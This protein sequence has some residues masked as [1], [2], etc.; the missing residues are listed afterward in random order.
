MAGT[1]NKFTSPLI[2]MESDVNTFSSAKWT[3]VSESNF[4]KMEE[5]VTAMFV[6]RQDANDLKKFEE[7]LLD[8]ST[9][10]SPNYGKWLKPEQIMEMISPEQADVQKVLD[11][12]ARFGVKD[13]KV[14]KFRDMVK[15]TMPVSTA[16]E[17]LSTE[18]SKFSSTVRPGVEVKRIT[19]PYF[20]PAEIADVIKYVDD[21]LRFPSMREPIIKLEGHSEGLKAGADPAFSSC[22]TKCSTFTTPAVLQEAYG[23]PTL[24]T[25]AAG[26]S[27]SVA[28]FQGQM[29]DQEDITDF[30]NACA[31]NAQVNAQYGDNNEDFCLKTGCIEAML[32]IEYIGAVANA[33]PLTVI[34]LKE[35]SLLDWVNQVIALP[36]PPLVHSVSYGNDEIQ[37]TSDAYM[38]TCNT[39]FQMAGSMGI[40]ILFASGD[41]GVW[42]R[43]GASKTG[44]Y[45][46]DFPASSPYITAVGGTN[47]QTKSVVGA[48]SA[49]DCG[50][51]GFSNYFAQPSWQSSQV[52]AYFAEAT[53]AGVLPEARLYNA[54]GRGY[55]DLAALGGQ[56]N[57][58]CISYKGG[59]FAGVAGT[60]ASSPVVAGI[61]ALLN[62]VRL[63]KGQ[64]SLG[65]L[66]PFIYQNG[67]CFNDVNDGTSNFCYK[68][69][70]GFA[71]LNG[72]DPATGFGTPNYS[73]LASKV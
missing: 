31:T 32:D 42:G 16:E 68:G 27:M 38:G 39:Q 48:Q 6:L 15:V 26:N 43:T 58:Y 4:R 47:F 33:I 8:I 1:T 45:N 73:C 17:M 44:T 66:N 72:W 19:Q 23:F 30:N 14:S 63:S 25:A 64:P 55:P 7:N 12:L 60:S 21:I 10:G 20:L 24:T 67:N 46:P 65:W 59:T 54:T 62:N 13:Y 53:A 69:Y 5:T 36:N 70:D 37:Q 3:K 52:S 9:P 61:F 40:S 41:Q 18:F 28:E 71:A 57:A 56:T 29:W 2:Q 22:G 11:F 49:W 50:G 35:F 51:G 34:Y